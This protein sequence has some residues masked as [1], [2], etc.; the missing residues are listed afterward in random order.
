MAITGS[1]DMMPVGEP[2]PFLLVNAA[3]T[4]LTYRPVYQMKLVSEL[5]NEFSSH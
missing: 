4:V 3:I 2:S 5:S 1:N